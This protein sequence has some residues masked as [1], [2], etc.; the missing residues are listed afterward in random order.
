[1]HFPHGLLRILA[2]DR[3]GLGWS[4]V[5]AGTPIVFAVSGE[6]FFQKLLSS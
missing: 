6:A 2:D 5:I 4:D 3:N 1:M